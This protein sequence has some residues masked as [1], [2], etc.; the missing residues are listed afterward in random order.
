MV[1]KNI[2]LISDSR[3]L[4]VS[5]KENNEPLV[6]LQKFPQ[7][8]LD[9]RK[10]EAS[11][12]FFKLRESVLK[13]L[14]G[15]QKY[16][17]KG[18]RFLVIEG[19]RLLSLQNKYFQNYSEKLFKNHPDWDKARIY[20]EASIFV[21]PPDIVPP[22]TTGGA[23]DLTLATEEGKELDM[24]TP[25]NISPI[26]CDEACFTSAENIS[27]EAKANR[28]LLIKAMSKAGFVNYPT[29]WWHWSYGD[30]YWAYFKKKSFA[31]YGTVKAGN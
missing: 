3:I 4:K 6:D 14:L 18:I 25:M 17:P 16:L 28:Q 1:S 21:A 22:H 10:G 15:A 26:R 27:K 7:I 23:V 11:D 2:I 19:H 13:K 8:L 24:G 29:E 12:S 30:K 20:K 5:I 31:F 9:T